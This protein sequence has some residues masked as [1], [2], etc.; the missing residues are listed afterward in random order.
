MRDSSSVTC[1]Q[2]VSNSCSTKAGGSIAPHALY[3]IGNS[4]SEDLSRV[5]ELL[6]RETGRT[7]TIE[8]LPM[9][10]GD[11]TDTYADISA[12]QRDHGFEPKTS[13]DEGVP[14]F[15]GWYRNYFGVNG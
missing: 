3:N 10:K 1:R 9:Q 14:R 5:I 11:V 2:I 6:E 13:I 12:I 15:V 7:A 8:K 4:R